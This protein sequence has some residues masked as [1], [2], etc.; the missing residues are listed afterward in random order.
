MLC[1]LQN[2]RVAGALGF[3]DGGARQRTAGTWAA[4]RTEGL[5]RYVQGVGRVCGGRGDEGRGTRSWRRVRHPDSSIGTTI[6]PVDSTEDD[7]VEGMSK[8]RG[9]WTR[10]AKRFAGLGRLRSRDQRAVGALFTVGD[11]GEWAAV[12]IG[13]ASQS[14]GRVGRGIRR[15]KTYERERVR[16][17]EDDAWRSRK[18]RRF[19]LDSGA[20]CESEPRPKGQGGVVGRR[21]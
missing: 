2:Q 17:E 14:D 7:Q 11:W 9:Q 10:L 13:V 6:K 12:A 18:R 4:W 21:R 15:R 3:G 5:G 1:V 8:G 20:N 19:G 16:R